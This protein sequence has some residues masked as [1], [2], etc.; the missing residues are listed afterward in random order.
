MRPSK[1]KAPSRTTPH[2]TPPSSSPSAL[3][4]RPLTDRSPLRSHSSHPPNPQNVSHLLCPSTNPQRSS[5]PP[6]RPLA[7]SRPRPLQSSFPK[8]PLKSPRIDS[9]HPA[10]PLDPPKPPTARKPQNGVPAPT[11][12][13]PVPPPTRIPTAASGSSRW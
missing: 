2:R 7:Q 13:S 11:P 4:H 3:R 9:S 5:V 8:P 12:P 6:L 1:L 10:P